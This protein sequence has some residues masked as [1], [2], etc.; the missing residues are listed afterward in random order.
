M[1]VSNFSDSFKAEI[2]LLKGS[3]LSFKVHGNTTRGGYYH[4]EMLAYNF[5]ASVTAGILLFER[6]GPED[7]I[8]F[9]C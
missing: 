3:A 5:I 6:S 1:F 8:F 4:R 9:S 7:I 2:F